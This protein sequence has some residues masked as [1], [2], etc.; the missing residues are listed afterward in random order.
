MNRSSRNPLLDSSVLR[1]HSESNSK[2]Q[3]SSLAKK[4]SGTFSHIKSDGSAAG[5][6]ARLRDIFNITLQK[7]TPSETLP[8]QVSRKKLELSKLAREKK[9]STS[10]IMKNMFVHNVPRVHAES[11]AVKGQKAANP[12]R[13]S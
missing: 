11:V 12:K 6:S 7:Q 9:R 3:T 5:V 4:P 13:Q 1:V 2:I 10:S 8:I